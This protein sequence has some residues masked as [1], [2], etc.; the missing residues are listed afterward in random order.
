MDE[1]MLAYCLVFYSKIGLFAMPNLPFLPSLDT[2][3]LSP[4][5]RSE[6]KVSHRNS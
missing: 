4:D 2:R 3:G 5:H 1:F 6:L